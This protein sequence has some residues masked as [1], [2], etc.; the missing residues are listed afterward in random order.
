MESGKWTRRDVPAM[1]PV[2]PAAVVDSRKA[3]HGNYATL[4]PH[5][6]TLPEQRL[7]HGRSVAL[8]RASEV[9]A[10]AGALCPRLSAALEG[11]AGVVRLRRACRHEPQVLLVSHS[12][13][14]AA[15]VYRSRGE[16]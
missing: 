16:L 1:L 13:V 15:R 8:H 10:D 2:H 14:A 6:P 3:R 9:R 5:L 4:P 7:R 12:R 11:L